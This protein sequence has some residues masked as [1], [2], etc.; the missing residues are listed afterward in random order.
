MWTFINLILF[1]HHIAVILQGWSW[2]SCSDSILENSTMLSFSLTCVNAMIV[3][4]VQI[5][6]S[7]GTQAVVTP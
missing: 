6:Q 3:N 7:T 5:R 1:Q 4:Q 2:R